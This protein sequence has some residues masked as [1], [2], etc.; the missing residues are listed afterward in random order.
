MHQR[1]SSLD[2]QPPFAKPTGTQLF[3]R[4]LWRFFFSSLVPMQQKRPRSAP[5]VGEID[6]R[7]DVP[8]EEERG[9]LSGDDAERT[10]SGSRVP[11]K[12]D[13][14]VAESTV[15]RDPN[16]PKVGDFLSLASR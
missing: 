4:L 9:L 6:G 14:V 16:T 11:M 2:S 8:G 7:E 15:R 1:C 13:G 12:V 5:S 3:V 10:L